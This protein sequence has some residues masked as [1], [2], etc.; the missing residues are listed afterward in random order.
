MLCPRSEKFDKWRTSF[1]DMWSLPCPFQLKG[2]LTGKFSRYSSRDSL[3]A[4]RSVRD[5]GSESIRCRV[6]EKDFGRPPPS[7]VAKNVI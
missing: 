1:L 2:R 7:T 4:W 3:H 6:D 5:L